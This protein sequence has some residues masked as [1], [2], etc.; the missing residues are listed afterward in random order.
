MHKIDFN[1]QNADHNN[2]KA[3]KL[4]LITL[5]LAVKNSVNIS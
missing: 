5:D 3:V 2:V 1:A 4:F